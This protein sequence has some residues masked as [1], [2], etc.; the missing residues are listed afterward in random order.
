MQSTP[1]AALR[2]SIDHIAEMIDLPGGVR[3]VGLQASIDPLSI[4]VVIE[5]PGLPET[6]L[7]CEAPRVWAEM[8]TRP[9]ADLGRGF[10]VER[11]FQW[12]TEGG[13]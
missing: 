6:P 2:L 8:V 4:L 5:G 3:V 10:F 7:D 9:I 12:P 11:R 1:R 13:A